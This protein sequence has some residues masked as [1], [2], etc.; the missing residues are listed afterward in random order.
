MSCDIALVWFP[1][2][3]L[4]IETCRNIQCDIIIIIIIIII[5]HIKCILLGQ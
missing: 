4:W 1:D 2:D 3:N 5:I